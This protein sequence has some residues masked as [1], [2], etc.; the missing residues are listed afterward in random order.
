MSTTTRDYLGPYRLVRLLHASVQS[1]V[2]EA[3]NQ[4]DNT[5]WAVKALQDKCRDSTDSIAALQAEFDTASKFKHP[6][7]IRIDRFA[8]DR[9][10]PYL[11]L[12]LF[13][14]PTLKQQMRTAGAT[15]LHWMAQQIIT[16][17]A[18][19]IGYVHAQGWVHRDIKPE[20]LLVSDQGDLRL[21]DF[22]I[23][24]PI[25]GGGWLSWLTGLASSKKLSGTRSYMSPEQIRN[26]SVD[27]AA[28]IYS[29]GCTIY[30]LLTGKLPYTGES[31]DDLLNK[32][33]KAPVPS[34]L[35]SNE[36]VTNEFSS[37][38]QRMMAKDKEK[39]TASMDD[40][41]KELAKIKIFRVR[42]NKPGSASPEK[43]S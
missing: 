39:R 28:D 21:I 41:L 23:A 9:G 2:W 36:N 8:T 31:S 16:K 15:S 22:S 24:Q 30:E 38:V 4:G 17:A 10:V 13:P 3:V 26:E 12:E 7:I 25:S 43:T 33:L 37:L 34:V 27:Q 29:F 42:P 20:N 32:H 19:V 11:V 5:R 18:E 6:N 40:F 1:Q 14:H 35:A